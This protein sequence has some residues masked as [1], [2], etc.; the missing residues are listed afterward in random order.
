MPRV[1]SWPA[2]ARSTVDRL[3]ES[4]DTTAASDLPVCRPSSWV[5]ARSRCA[6]VPCHAVY[7]G[8]KVMVR[9]HRSDELCRCITRNSPAEQLSASAASRH[10]RRGVILWYS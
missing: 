6:A 7:L 5:Q 3:T 9:S 4:C 1:T 8:H 10:N 2:H